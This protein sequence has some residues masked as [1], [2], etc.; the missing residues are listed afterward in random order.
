MAAD[1]DLVVVG[2]GIAG[3][4]AAFFARRSGLK[5]LLVEKKLPGGQ[6][7]NAT[8]VEFFPGFPAGIKGMELAANLEKQCVSHG[9]ETVTAEAY[10]VS[11][12]EPFVVRTT[13]GSWTAHAVVIATGAEP[14]KLEVPG[15]ER[16]EGRGVSHCANCDGHFFRGQPV[17]VV[18]GGDSALDEAL[19][20]ASVASRVSIIHRRRQL[21]ACKHLQDNAL[22][23][24]RIEFIWDSVVEAIEG[25]D[26]V[27][28]VRLR[29]RETGEIQSLRVPG[30]FVYVGYRPASHFLMGTVDTTEEGYLTVSESMETS[31]PG[32]FAAGAVRASSTGQLVAAAADGARAALSAAG[33]ICAS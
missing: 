6:L 13:D 28:S 21:R 10:G 18:G 9:V 15:E 8:V 1:W 23:H 22:A 31:L 19:H 14:R 5:T 33:R 4:S 20:L 29:N 7:V 2:G 27:E 16:F 26:A 24:P 25:V 12:G 32:L 30:I 11:A 3:L 17:A